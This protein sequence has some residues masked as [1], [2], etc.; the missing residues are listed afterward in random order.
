[1]E[2]DLVVN[3]IGGQ[4]R[5]PHAS[6]ARPRQPLQDARGEAR[7]PTGLRAMEEGERWN[8]DGRYDMREGAHDRS[9]GNA[10]CDS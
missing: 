10:Q 3:G 5:L 1:M 7:I 2:Q 6:H 8:G 4:V 9:E